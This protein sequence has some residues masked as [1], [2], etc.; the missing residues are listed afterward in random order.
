MR[1]DFGHNKL[2]M[3]MDR[4]HHLDGFFDMIEDHLVQ[5]LNAFFFEMKEYWNL[6]LLI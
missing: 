2:L 6:I 3:K 4:D 5:F 1:L